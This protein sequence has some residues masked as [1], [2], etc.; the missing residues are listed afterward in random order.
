MKLDALLK[1]G[2]ITKDEYEKVKKN[3]KNSL[4]IEKILKICYNYNEIGYDAN[5]TRRELWLS[6]K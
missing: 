2:L 1:Q 4:L 5:D 3:F 6:L